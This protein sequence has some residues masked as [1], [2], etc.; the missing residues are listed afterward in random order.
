M[1]VMLKKFRIGIVPTHFAV[2]VID[3]YVACLFL[4]VFIDS[5]LVNL[6]ITSFNCWTKQKMHDILWD[7]IGH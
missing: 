5:R 4:L 1:L 2:K 6:C 3:A 7:I